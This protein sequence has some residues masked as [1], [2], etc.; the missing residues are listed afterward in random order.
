MK[1]S[2]PSSTV[3]SATSIDSSWT[4]DPLNYVVRAFAAF[5]QT[6]FET[7]PKGQFHWA[8]TMEDTELVITEENPVHLDVIERKPAISLILGPMRFSGT[9]LD[10]LVSLDQATGREVHTDLLPGTM[11]LHCLSRVAQEARFLAWLSARTIWNL[12]KLF[13]HETYIHEVGR[14]ITVG[15]VSPAGALVQGDT[16]AEWHVVPVQC[17][18]FLQWTDSITPLTKDWTGQNVQLAREVTV[19]LQTKMGPIPKVERHSAI[20]W[21]RTGGDFRPPRRRGKPIPRPPQPGGTSIPLDL[22]IKV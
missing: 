9:S 17:P 7:A 6:I 21:N 10:D 18:F 19:G 5:L 3:P 4:N 11:S 2:D 16:E 12:R 22:E 14:N 15:S 13:I 1:P 8:P 20:T